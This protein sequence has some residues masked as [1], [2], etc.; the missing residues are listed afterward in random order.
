MAPPAK[1]ASTPKRKP[2]TPRPP[3]PAEE[4]LPK[5][6][7]ALTDQVDDGY[8]ENAIKTCKKILAVDASSQTAFQ[9][10][11]F[12]HLQTDDYTSALS[13]LDHPSHE[14]SLDF[15]RAYCLYRLHREK[16]ALEVLKGLNEKGRKMDHLEAQ[17]LYRLGEYSQAQEIYENMLANSDV[18]SPEHADIVTNLSATTAHLEFDAHGYHSHLST[19]IS[20]TSQTP[21]NAADLENI[22]PSLPTGWSTG[23]LAATVEKKTAAVKAP[24]EK[25]KRS[26]PRH[27]LPK[28]AVA[29][30]E[31]TEDLERWIPLRQRLS[32]ITAQSKKKGAKESMGTGF[33][34]GSTGGHSAGSGAGGKN[35][36]GKR[37]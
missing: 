9:T 1:P 22:V 32:Y 36:K 35:K 33:T 17:I 37:K 13:L 28:G 14:G 6:Y 26:R 10:L 27:K 30:N 25:N 29:G 5:L 8:F 4:R 2:F 7:R 34:Q 31:F 18:S 24:E 23:G 15:E 19:T 12:L 20:S 21:M 16:E 3:R 11:L